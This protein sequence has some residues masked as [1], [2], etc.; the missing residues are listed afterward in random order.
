MWVWVKAIGKDNIIMY[1]CCINRWYLLVRLSIVEKERESERENHVLKT[2]KK[3]EWDSQ[4][5]KE[6]MKNIP[7]IAVSNSKKIEGHTIE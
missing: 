5:E 2:M 7:T 6:S 1:I 3:V 4:R